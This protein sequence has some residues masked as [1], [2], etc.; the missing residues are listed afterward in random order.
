MSTILHDDHDTL[1]RDVP[2]K[3]LWNALKSHKSIIS[4]GISMKFVAFRWNLLF[5][6]LGKGAPPCKMWG[7]YCAPVKVNGLHRHVYVGT[8]NFNAFNNK[9]QVLGYFKYV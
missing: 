9:F 7:A 3:V 4:L 5:C 6:T 8:Y 1:Q 2:F